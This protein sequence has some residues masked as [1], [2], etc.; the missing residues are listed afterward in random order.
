VSRP[1]SRAKVH[2]LAWC[3]SPGCEWSSVNKNHTLAAAR[4]HADSTGHE[5]LVEQSYSIAY[6]EP[7]PAHT[8][9]KG[10]GR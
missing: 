5:V 7:A 10:E 2:E 6:N 8:E 9:D 1:T 4:R 3:N